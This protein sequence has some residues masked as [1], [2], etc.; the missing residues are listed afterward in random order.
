MASTQTKQEEKLKIETH[1]L[2]LMSFY[3]GVIR[4]MMP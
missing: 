1:K 2:I 4:K 3:V